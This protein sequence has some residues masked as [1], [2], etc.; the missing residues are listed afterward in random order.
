MRLF[1]LRRSTRRKRSKKDRKGPVSLR[2]VDDRLHGA[3]AD[4]LDRG[5]AEPNAVVD[6]REMFV[7]LIDVRGQHRN[8]EPATFG[9]VADDLV[10]IAHVGRHQRRHEFGRV[11]GLE[12]GCLVTD[13]RIGGGV[14][15]VEP[16]AGELLDQLIQLVGF[17]LRNFFLLRPF[18][19]LTRSFSISSG[20]FLPMARRRISACPSENPA[21][22]LAMAMTCS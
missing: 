17:F 15:L 14:R 2:I 9:E 12:V 18:Q 1:T 6:D 10:R 11:M 20:F 21:T 3:F 19:E 13:H 5:H 8:A 4:V 22:L 7:A 16:V